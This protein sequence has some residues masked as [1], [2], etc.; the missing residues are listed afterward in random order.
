MSTTHHHYIYLI[1]DEE[2]D[3]TSCHNKLS[4]CMYLFALMESDIIYL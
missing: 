1:N 3:S 2:Y 4:S